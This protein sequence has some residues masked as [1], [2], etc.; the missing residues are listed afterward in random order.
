[1]SADTGATSRP[2]GVIVVSGPGGVGKGT[3]VERAVANDGEIA[4][5]RSWTTRDR[6]PGEAEDAYVFVDEETFLARRDDG[7]F[8]EW[9]HFL[10]G[11]YYASP[12]PEIGA[13]KDLLLEIDVNGAR[14]IHENGTANT[15]YVFIDTVTPEHQRARLVGR[16]DTPEQVERRME[17]GAQ[18]REMAADLPYV[19]IV[20]DDLDRAVDDLLALIVEYRSRW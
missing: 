13:G 20:N 1:M 6:R 15:L 12:V 11:A 17:A 7:G 9:N 4:L 5:S 10:G 3:V 8:L 19:H 18:E 2:V 16:G 14:Q